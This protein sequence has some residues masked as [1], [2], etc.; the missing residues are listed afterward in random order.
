MLN[1]DMTGYSKGTIDA[2]KPESFGLITDFT[3]PTLN[4]YIS[5]VIEEV[6][7]AKNKLSKRSQLTT[8]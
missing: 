8:I 2:G 5:R 1:Q 7:N 3:D 4:E 6:S